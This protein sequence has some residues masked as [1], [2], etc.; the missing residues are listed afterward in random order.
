MTAQAF[1]YQEDQHAI[2]HMP[3]LDPQGLYQVVHQRH[4]TMCGVIP[5]TAALPA[6]QEPGATSATL[7]R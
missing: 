7:V 5:I 2:D 4:L 3:M 6:C 1:T